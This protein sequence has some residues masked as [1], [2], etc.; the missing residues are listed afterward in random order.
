MYNNLYLIFSAIDCGSLLAPEDGM[1]DINVT[2]FNNTANYS[3][4]TG[5]E[6]VGDQTRTCLASGNW[7]GSQ[8]SCDGK[9][10]RV[11]S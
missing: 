8:P 6:L 9:C 10:I 4:V 3:C 2:T 5:Y 11:C 7:S 1:I